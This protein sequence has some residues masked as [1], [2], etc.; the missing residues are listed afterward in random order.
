MELAYVSK[1]T[2]THYTFDN[3]YTLFGVPL[4][5]WAGN[6]VLNVY[7]EYNFYV[8][9]DL[10]IALQ[11]EYLNHGDGDLIHPAEYSIERGE[12]P[13]E[14]P[15][16][17]LILGIRLYWGTKLATAVWYHVGDTNARLR[18]KLYLRHSFTYR[19]L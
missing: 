4:G 5:C 9:E 19:L 10:R 13:T 3:A 15:V 16:E 14:I 12:P 11:C 1:W 2:Y 7:M 18:F 17:W 6:D 8:G